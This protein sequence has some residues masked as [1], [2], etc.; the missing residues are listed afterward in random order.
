[1]PGTRVVVRYSKAFEEGTIN[2]SGITSFK[3]C[4]D[5][6]VY[7][8]CAISGK[9]NILNITYYLLLILSS[10]SVINSLPRLSLNLPLVITISTFITP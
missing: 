4:M 2:Q 5:L 1:M 6:Y 8:L 10:P 9:H 3:L 7:S